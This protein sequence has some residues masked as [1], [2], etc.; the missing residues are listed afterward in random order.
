MGV[1]IQKLIPCREESLN[2]E[3]TRNIYIEGDN[4]D[5]LQLLQKQYCGVIRLIYIDP[6]YNTG[7]SFVYSDNFRSKWRSMMQ[8]RLALARNL[9][10]DT[11]L[12]F[13]SIDHHELWTLKALCDEIFDGKNYISV[14]AVENNPKGRK[15]S[16][17]FSESYEFCLVYAKDKRR[18][19]GQLSARGI[20][21]FFTGLQNNNPDRRKTLRDEYGVFKQSKRQICGCNKSG[22]LACVSPSERCFAIYWLKNADGEY[23][24]LINE[25]DSAADSWVISDRGRELL[26]QGWTRYTGTHSISGKPAIPLYSK[27]TIKKLFDSHSLYF[28]TDG[29]IYEKQR[30]NK[31]QITSF[32]PNKRFGLDLMTESATAQMEKLFGVQG[33]FTNSKSVDFIKTIIQQYPDNTIT[34]LDFFSG[35]AAAAHA[36]MQLNAEDGGSRRFIMVQSREPC[37]PKSHA[38]GAGYANICEIGKERIRRAG[39]K[40]LEETGAAHCDIGFRLYRVAEI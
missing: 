22:T 27:E 37:A 31:K 34:V 28:K 29:A 10:A 17:F 26:S 13:I 4:L 35:S 32:L 25:Y 30:E 23:L 8:P 21:K 15:N 24:E 18:I 20:K 3:T 6:P 9:L 2:W 1:V 19:S 36:V 40:I 7:K 11:G 5:A 14:L 39:K 33:I 16:A 12:I 38:A